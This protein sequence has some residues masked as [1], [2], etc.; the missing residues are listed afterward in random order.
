MLLPE[1][2]RKRSRDRKW[3]PAVSIMT[4][5]GDPF[6]SVRPPLL[7]I[8]QSYHITLPAVTK[9]SSVPACGGALHTQVTPHV[10]LALLVTHWSL[11]QDR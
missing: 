8:L 1:L 3:I 5:S 6:P 7:K 4:H 10:K 2:M 11:Y 9:T